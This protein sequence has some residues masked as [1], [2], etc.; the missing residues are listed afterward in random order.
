MNLDTQI[1]QDLEV[2]RAENKVIANQ[3]FVQ[4]KTI[5]E[6]HNNSSKLTEVVSNF[7]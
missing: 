5:F 7:I 2:L 1:C 3:N 4:H 6:L